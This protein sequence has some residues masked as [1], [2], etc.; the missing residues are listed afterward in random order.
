[1][2]CT[3][4]RKVDPVDSNETLG[5]EKKFGLIRDFIANPKTPSALRFHRIEQLLEFMESELA[6][7]VEEENS[8]DR[9]YLQRDSL[10]GLNRRRSE[11]EIL[12][13]ILKI[14]SNM[15]ARKTKILYQANL[16]GYQ[17]KNYLSFLT[18]AG[19][20]TKVKTSKK[21]HSYHTTAKGK[22]FLYHW[23]RLLSLLESRPGAEL[24]PEAPHPSH[25]V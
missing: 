6:A 17:L 10:E 14:A 25:P 19:L 5:Y 11:F 2:V 7:A 16:S 23:S 18:G 22:L 1:V 20:I 24:H 15:G 9:V 13:F 8:V 3:E 4:F 21:S 12:A